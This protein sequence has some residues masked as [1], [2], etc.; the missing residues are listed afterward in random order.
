MVI[1]VDITNAFKFEVSFAA[2]ESNNF[3]WREDYNY[4]A[5]EL[6]I[7]LRYRNFNFNRATNPS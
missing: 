3:E 7:A 5:F 2:I 1:I 4:S 6:H